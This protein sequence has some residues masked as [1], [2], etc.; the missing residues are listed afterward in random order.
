MIARRRGS[1]STDKWPGK[2]GDLGVSVLLRAEVLDLIRWELAAWGSVGAIGAARGPGDGSTGSIDRWGN[3]LQIA[4][5]GEGEAGAGV[6]VGG[7]GRR[8]LGAVGR[9]AAAA[10]AAEGT[11]RSVGRS[12]GALA[13]PV[14]AAQAAGAGAPAVADP[15]IAGGGMLR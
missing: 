5:V 1:V 9:G 6:A 12:A 7:P 10:A 14:G 8:E 2:A 11:N 3:G 15:A 4:A 13:W